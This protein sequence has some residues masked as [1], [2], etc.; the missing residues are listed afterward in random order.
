MRVSANG[1]TSSRKISKISVN[2][3]GFSN[4][5]AELALKKPPPLLPS[6]LMTSCEATGP[7]TMVWCWPASVVTAWPAL[8]LSMTPPAARISAPANAIG[9]S[10]RSTHRVTST[11]K[12]PSRSVLR[13][14]NPRTIAMAIA[15]PTA[16]EAKFCT[17]RPHICTM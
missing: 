7:P 14:M 2:G 1:M 15:M 8:K 10:S 6:S 9:S 5:C 11:Q 13:R 3:F 17:A 12:L 16:A 4:G